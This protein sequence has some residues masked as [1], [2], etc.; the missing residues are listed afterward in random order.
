VRA[1]TRE[2]AQG[3]LDR[4]IAE[5]PIELA[6]V[7]DIDRKEA[8]ELA[9]RYFGSLPRRPFTETGLEPLRDLDYEE[10]R[11]SSTVEVP[12]VTPTAVVLE[13]WR[14]A[15][16]TEVKDRRLLQIA[17]RILT[18]RLR[19]EIREDRGLTYTIWC[20]AR[21]ARGFPGTG[22]ITVQFTA[23]PDGAAEV[24][25][26]ARGVVQQFAR[27]GPTEEEIATVRRQFANI[28]ETSQKKPGYWVGLLS[29]MDY[30]GTKLADVKNALQ[31]YTSYTREDM[32]E[33]LARYVVPARRL[34]AIALPREEP[35]GAE[36]ET[37]PK[38]A[39]TAK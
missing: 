30:R 3:W 39:P 27:E 15:N 36:P 24:A 31:A 2:Q 5:S 34:E 14:G 9:R 4:M 21:A 13:G 1:L 20:V 19:E 8:L 10:G 7:G 17:S 25:E 33:V 32:M 16:W 26:I 12:T 22:H 37:Q 18:S 11:L 38:M 23:D 6:V 35:A 28:I 29:E